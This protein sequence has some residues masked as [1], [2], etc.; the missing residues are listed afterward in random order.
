MTLRNILLAVVCFV[1]A[2]AT[3]SQFA[4]QSAED[5]ALRLQGIIA[6]GAVDEFKKIRRFPWGEMD[7][8]EANYVFG[9]EGEKGFVEF[10]G[11]DA[12]GVRVYGPYS[13]GVPEYDGYAAVYTVVY[14]DPDKISFNEHG[15]IDPVLMEKLWG[16]G[17]L[18]TQITY[19]DNQWMFH[20]TPFFY[21]AHAPW[22]EDYGMLM[23]V[24][25][26]ACFS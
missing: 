22:A 24:R 10:L 20:R 21:G 7:E 14:Y 16:D 2:C 5:F 9:L 15:H 19:S 18:E 3:D 17:Y 8:Y 1:P 4:R 25:L 13:M 23:P 11:K 12:A 26:L 6:A